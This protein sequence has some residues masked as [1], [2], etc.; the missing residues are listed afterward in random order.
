MSTTEPQQPALFP[1]P[2]E[3]AQAGAGAIEQAAALTIDAL[4]E[5]G[6]LDATHA[7]KVELI[8]AGARALD[9]EFQREKVTTAAGNLFS[10]VVDIADGLP[11][12]QQAVADSFER[13]TQA[14]AD[15]D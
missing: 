14:L 12:V 2:A 11:T 6:G 3:T 1:D 9:V 4:R 8:L 10:R 7:L 15:A 13:M 5:H